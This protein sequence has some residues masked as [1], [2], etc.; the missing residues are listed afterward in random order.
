MHS[1]PG[2]PS[3]G[4]C[5]EY[6]RRF[7]LPRGGGRRNGELCLEIG[8]VVMTSDIMTYRMLAKLGLTLASFRVKGDEPKRPCTIDNCQ[9]KKRSTS[10]KP[11]ET[12]SWSC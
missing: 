7:R 8:P 10:R 3:V 1:Q 4:R 2:H 12:F 6:W 11:V 9:A 5:S